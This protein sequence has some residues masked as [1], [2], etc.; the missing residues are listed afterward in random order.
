MF[1]L[2]TI[3]D[4]ANENHPTALLSAVCHLRALLHV[5]LTGPALSCRVRGVKP[6]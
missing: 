6:E 2:L 3:W 5:R 4:V 1:F